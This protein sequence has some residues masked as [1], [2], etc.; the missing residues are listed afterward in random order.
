MKQKVMEF[1]KFDLSKQISELRNSNDI[2]AAIALCR[3]ASQ[4]FPEENIFWKILGD[5][6]YKEENFMESLDAYLNFLTLIPDPRLFNNFARFYHRLKN[7][8]NI[9]YINKRI[10]EFITNCK[11]SNGVLDNLF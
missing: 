4:I 1:N 7:N 3:K 5:L 11:L 6:L 10:L 8:K 9:K 2:T